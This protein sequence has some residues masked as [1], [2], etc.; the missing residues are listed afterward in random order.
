MSNRQTILVF[1]AGAILGSA[2]VWYIMHQP[3]I[4]PA[5]AEPWALP[6]FYYQETPNALAGVD[7]AV[8]I[9]GTLMGNDVGYP[10]N[11]QKI[12]CVQSENR[13]LVAD[14]EEIGRRQLGEINMAYWP[15]V[16][17]TPT[18]IVARN[19]TDDEAKITQPCAV[20][21]ITID[22]QKKAVSYLSEPKNSGSKFCTQGRKIMG[23]LSVEDWQIGNPIQ[24]WGKAM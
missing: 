24:P 4:G 19:V 6:V 8:D 14:V 9:T 13:C 1:V 7:S 3:S 18:S 2:I 11:T 21:T 23:T 16:S 10:V 22:R 12:H 20:D 17:W 5:K 15:V